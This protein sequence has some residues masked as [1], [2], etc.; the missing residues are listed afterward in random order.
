MHSTLARQLRRLWGVTSPEE[1]QVVCARARELAGNEALDPQL[2]AA[3]A[4][5]QGLLEKVDASYE[6]FDRDLHLRTR[7]L[8]LSSED[9]IASNTRLAADLASRTRAIASLQ[10]LV[11]PMALSNSSFA[12]PLGDEADDLETL[13]ASISALVEQLH[14]ERTELRN[15][16][17][18]V[19]DHA[20][21]SITDTAG[22]ITYVNDR[23]CQISGYP[24]HELLGQSHRIIKSG[25][26]P[27]AFFESL[28]RT[29]TAGRVWRGEV[30]NRTRSGEL[31][32]VQAT[33]MPFVDNTGRISKFIAIRTDVTERK[34]MGEQVA[35]SE[36][37]YRSTVDSLR[38]T[39][40]RANAEGRL[41]FLN[42]A[43][44]Q[45]TG[46]RVADSVGRPLT[47]F[48]HPDD[49]AQCMADLAALVSGAKPY[50]RREMR[51]TTQAGEPIWMEA[52]AQS[53]F[54]SAGR[55]EGVTGT[56][57]DVSERKQAADALS[58]QLAFIDALVEC[59]PIPL[60]VKNREGRYLRVNP[61][62]TAYFGV[63]AEHFLGHNVDESHA[64]ARNEMHN[65]SDRQ[66]FDEGRNVNY[67]FHMTLVDGREVDCTVTKAAL[68]DSQGT[69]RADVVR[70]F[71]AD[72]GSGTGV[73]VRAANPA[74]INFGNVPIGTTATARTAFRHGDRRKRCAARRL[75]TCSR[76]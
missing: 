63:P 20:I 39:V 46:Y 8:E 36:H 15:L 57:N 47:A 26:H 27:P 29:I 48:I 2:R 50:C 49:Q 44:E 73:S 30:C 68:R 25:L 14:D 34:R 11:Q 65:I 35:R 5:L 61:A 67:E 60:F 71:G 37:Q 62:Y 69:G 28:W 16:K 76:P 18:A 21:V 74:S 24:R 55:F 54:D 17:S 7:S 3:L 31:F 58:E 23:F 43:W 72:V 13:S 75:S 6:Q 19:D 32:W 9:L 42:A 1:A 45:T 66:V 22:V 59:N 56:L 33:I 40:F 53:V 70:S 12:M 64:Q 52:Y 10:S 4:G 38:E 51:Y 41:T